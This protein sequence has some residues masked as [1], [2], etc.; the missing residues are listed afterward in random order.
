MYND[1]EQVT[2]QTKLQSGDNTMYYLQDDERE[3][4]IHGVKNGKT[5]LACWWAC[6]SDSYL[7]KHPEPRD[8]FVTFYKEQH[9]LY[10]TKLNY[11]LGV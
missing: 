11:K 10:L 2:N 4:I 5:C 7:L 3:M 6:W 9:E 8:N 1:I